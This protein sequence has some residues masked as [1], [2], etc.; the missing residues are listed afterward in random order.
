VPDNEEIQ[1]QLALLKVEFAAD[2]VSR[3]DMMV[4]ELSVLDDQADYQGAL[5]ELFRKIHSLSGSSGTFGYSRLSTQ[6]RQLELILKGFIS[7]HSVLDAK[8]NDYLQ[9][10]L[11][12]IRQ[13][14]A[15]GPD[16]EQPIN[17]DH[18]PAVI[19][20][21]GVRLV[22]VV[23]D[24]AY[25]GQEL[26]AQLDH[27]G[28]RTRLFTNATEAMS[29]MEQERP[30][31]M[32]LDIILPEGM[33]AGTELAVRVGKLLNEN[34]PCIFI[35]ARKD[36]ESRLAAVRAG[37]TA[38][39][40][41]PVEASVLV[42]H[43]DRITQRV[44]REPYRVLIVD[45]AK[46]LAQHYVLVLRQAGMH[47][48]LLTEPANILEELDSFKPELILLD[49]Y[50]PDMSGM[51]IAKVLRQHQTHFSIPIV[52]LSTEADPDIQLNTLQQGDDF[53]EKPILDAY[54]VSA[55]ESRIERARSLSKLMYHDGLTGLLNHVTLKQRLEVELA[56]SRRQGS[57]LSYVMLDLDHFKQVNDRFGHTA[58]DRV[59]KSLARLLQERLR[60]SD[61]I[62]RYGGEEF[63]V[64]L[65][66]TG[67]EKALQIIE[68]VHRRF[69]QLIFKSDDQDFT[70][71]FSAGIAC[72]SAFAEEKSILEAADETL[73]QAKERGRNLVLVH[74]S[75]Q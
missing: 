73:Y 9:Y 4:R 44:Q 41:K 55:V 20:G 62:G 74:S 23:E 48:E 26:C 63:G 65:P 2:L 71:T 24:E 42:D 3:L 8:S 75:C 66:D 70:S 39:L 31:A 19:Q 67:P 27:Y 59:L 14:I 13:L 32:V 10:G 52:F 68:D 29:A 57:P 16:Q 50:F 36:W 45:D 51:E 21:K 61:Q 58:G 25:Q 64:I 43:L 69:A 17:T 11:Q 22:Y 34:I 18:K 72:S 40:D 56:R 6:S 7:S 49:F 1:R 35:S 47:A 33:L 28:F 15:D 53:L 46:E 38:Y 60:L 54:L 30:D 12:K 37:G 5:Q